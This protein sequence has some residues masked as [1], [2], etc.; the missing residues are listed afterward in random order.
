MT[1]TWY[2]QGIQQGLQQGLQEGLEEGQ[3]RLVRS[4]IEL[5]FGPLSQR[6]TN[7]L[8]TWP[9]ERLEELGLAVVKAQTLEE[10]G[11]EN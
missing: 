9:V 4:Q 10:L 1:M 8:T 3:R 7:R 11:L 6:A 5:R 2:D